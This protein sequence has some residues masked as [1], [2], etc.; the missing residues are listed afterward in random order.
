MHVIKCKTTFNYFYYCFYVL[1]RQYTFYHPHL[2]LTLPTT[3]PLGKALTKT[4]LN[5]QPHLYSPLLILEFNH[6]LSY[7]FFKFAQIAT[8]LKDKLFSNVEPY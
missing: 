2:K 5:L 1:Y 8:W 7:S 3:I 4:A 6:A